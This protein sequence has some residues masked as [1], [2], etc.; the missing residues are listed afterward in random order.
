MFNFWTFANGHVG[1]Q[2]ASRPMGLLLVIQC[3]YVVSRNIFAN[4]QVLPLAVAKQSAKVHEP[5]VPNYNYGKSCQKQVTD[6]NREERTA[7]FQQSANWTQQAVR[8][9]DKGPYEQV[10]ISF[11]PWAYGTPSNLTMCYCAIKVWGKYPCPCVLC[12]CKSNLV[13][14]KSYRISNCREHCFSRFLGTYGRNVSQRCFNDIVSV[15][16]QIIYIMSL[17]SSA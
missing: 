5:I 13:T 1:S 16:N 17:W 3:T 6:I 12:E 8:L 9:P 2:R 4:L 11:K 15:F 14:I 7:L 10:G